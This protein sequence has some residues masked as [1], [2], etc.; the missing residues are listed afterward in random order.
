MAG[1]SV[2]T[3]SNALNGRTEA[4]APETL[5]RIQQTIRALNYRPSQ[6]ARSLVTKQTATIGVVLAEIDTPLFFQ[7]LNDIE[8]V[9]R[10]ADHNI[11]L[12]TTKHNLSDEAQVL[13]L[14]LEKQVDG[15][16]LLST[17]VLVED[18]YLAGLPLSTPPIVLINRS[19]PFNGRFDQISFDHRQGVTDAVTYLVSLGHRRI[20]H[21]TGPQSR[22]STLERLKG[23]RLGLAQHN[24]PFVEDYL[25]PADFDQ[26]PATWER[27]TL[28]LLSVSPRPTAVIAANDRV[29]AIVMRTAQNQGLQIPRD[30]SIIGIDDQPF[31]LYLNPAL[32]TVQLPLIEASRKATRLLLEMIGG[33]RSTAQNVILP[34]PL[35]VRES[36]GPA[37]AGAA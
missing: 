22:V 14:L 12:A 10:Q 21:L 27:A 26:S 5:L 29:A 36:T 30:I 8:T 23:Y 37:P 1:V 9:A 28:K 7:T 18:N 19:I 35:I 24:L 13:D 4:M 33:Q 6:V 17:S 15:L 32:T 31:C 11:L 20:A 3:V 34:C 25:R 2:T 16:I